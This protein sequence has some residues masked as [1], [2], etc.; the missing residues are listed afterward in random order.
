LK[1]AR[2]YRRNSLG[3]F[4]VA[5]VLNAYVK[6]FLGELSVICGCAVAAAIAAAAAIGDAI[7]INTPYHR[8]F[9]KLAG[10]PK[11]GGYRA[12]EVRV[13]GQLLLSNQRC[14]LRRFPRSVIGSI[15]FDRH[16]ITVDQAAGKVW[17]NHNEDP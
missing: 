17:I 12:R 3:Y 15:F 7:L 13:A 5:H 16:I 2:K 11:A 8:A 6:C 14:L 4:T 9:R 1:P 10:D